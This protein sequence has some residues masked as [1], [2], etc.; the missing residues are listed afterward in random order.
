MNHLKRLHDHHLW[1]SKRILR[2]IEE[3][4]HEALHR[5]FPIGQGTVWRSVCHLVAADY[6][7]LESLQGNAYAYLPGD[8]PNELPGNQLGPEA[9]KDLKELETF[10]T[11][12]HFSW[13]EFLDRTT[14]QDL[15]EKPTERVQAH[16]QA[17]SLALQNRMLFCTSSFTRSTQK[18]KSL[19]CCGT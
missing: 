12:L 2:T 8:L 11:K 19:T 15:Q 1:S 4:S 9:F 18:L 6:I 13:S 5:Q 7:W 14:D 10:W 16:L 3:L 17:K